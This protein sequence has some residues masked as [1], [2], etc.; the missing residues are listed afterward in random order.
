MTKHDEPRIVSAP[1]AGAPVEGPLL[2]RAAWVRVLPFVTY[3]FFIVAADVLER[4]GL[5]SADLRWLYPIKI[6][7]VALLLALFWRHY[8]ELKLSLPGPRVALVAAAAGVAVL[9][10]WISLNADWMIVGSPSGFDPRNDGQ[11]DWAWIA[12]R[13]AGAALVVP[14]MEELFWRSF[15]MRSFEAADFQSVDPAQAG[16]KS[17]VATIVLFGFEH[18]L[19]LAGMVA[20]AVYSALYMRH[21]TLWSP[22]LAHAVTNGLLGIWV[23]AT[24]S[25]SYW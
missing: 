4:L 20:G 12:V 17:L 15:L 3:V 18:N 16:L 24:G 6:A 10:L 2:G 11:L 21:R 25:W 22:I 8:T 5:S 13:L 19:W 23:I 7:A 9:V 14:V 1:V